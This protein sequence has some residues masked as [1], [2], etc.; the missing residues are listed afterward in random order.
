MKAAGQAGDQAARRPDPAPR[1][2][3]ALMRTLTDGKYLGLLH[4]KR[5]LTRYEQW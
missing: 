3:H 4:I 2:H 1:A 5:A